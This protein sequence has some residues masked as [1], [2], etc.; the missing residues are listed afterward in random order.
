MLE[1]NVLEHV[2]ALVYLLLS[3]RSCAVAWQAISLMHLP[4]QAF[5]DFQCRVLFVSALFLHF[6]DGRHIRILL[7][8]GLPPGLPL[9]VRETDPRTETS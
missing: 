5:D 1:I 9:T 7:N 4:D 2:V 6:C 3:L 8:C